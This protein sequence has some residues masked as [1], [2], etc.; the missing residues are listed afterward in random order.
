MSTATKTP[1]SR[2]L[3][4]AEAFRRLFAGTFN[5]WEIAGSIRRQRPDVGDV[6][7]VVIPEWGEV[8][9]GGG[10]FANP[11]RTNLIWQRADKLI[12]AGTIVKHLYIGKKGNTHKWGELL[13]GIDYQGFHHE[14]WTATPDNWGSALAIH[15][16]PWE[17]SK[18]LVIGLQ[19]NG[20]MNHDGYVRNKQAWRCVC[21]WSGESPTWG[22]GRMG[23]FAR[24]HKER[25]IEVPSC[26]ACKGGKSVA[27]VEVPCPDEETFFRM[28]GMAFVSPE[29]RDGGRP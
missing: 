7:H 27:P 16:G 26:P 13:R 22:P 24:H 4:V 20:Y 19:R 5:R 21:G 2:A 17:F 1:L 29:R 23:E 3:A 6:D 14:I 18:E 8:E 25:G 15:T 28:A 11:I 10:L 9:A 12:A